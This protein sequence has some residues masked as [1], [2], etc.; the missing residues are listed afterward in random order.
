MTWVKIC[1]ITN[2]GDALTAVEAGADALGFVF[3]EKSPRNVSPEAVREIVAGLPTEVEKVGVFVGNNP[4]SFLDVVHGS[5]LTGLQHH[6]DRNAGSVNGSAAYGA[7]CFPPGFKSYLSIP[8]EWL[9]ESKDSG[10][11]FI[12]SLARAAES[13]RSRP[14]SEAFPAFLQTIFLDSGNLQQPG[15]TGM[16]FDW[17]KAAPMVERLK[18]T[19]RVVVAGG[20][21]PTNVS[22]AIRILKP[23]GVDVSSGVESKPGKKDPEKVQAFVAAVRRAERVV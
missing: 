2:T 11:H 21:D 15:G 12:S 7:G 19:V 1:G 6:F 4:E 9:L 8:A 23:W 3:Y 22:E 13:R 10:S 17:Q 16:A 14:G 5:G 18:Q 20:L